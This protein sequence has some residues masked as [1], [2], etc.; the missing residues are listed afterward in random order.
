MLCAGLRAANVAGYPEE[1]FWHGNHKALAAA[2]ELDPGDQPSLVRAA[3][4]RGTSKNGVFGCK[5]MW[6]YLDDACA[7]LA[8]AFEVDPR[9][10]NA[11]I[12]QASFPDLRLV[13]LERADSVAQAISYARA[14]QSDVWAIVAGA[15]VRGSQPALEL[16]HV[17][18]G[19]SSSSPHRFDFHAVE[20]FRREVE[21]HNRAWRA[22][23][24][25]SGFE[26]VR[27]EFEDVVDDYEAT[28]TRVVRQL[29]L[30]APHED[31]NIPPPATERQSGAQ[32]A[33]WRL[34]YEE[35]ALAPHMR[36]I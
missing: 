30:V 21:R 35:R 17:G 33:R 11:E 29:G 3:I 27:V 34:R 5:V 7:M 1:Y 36:P 26:P 12:L 18:G 19:A 6:G 28:I 4:E 25:L 23:F 10:S 2:W 9:Q 14:V 15:E 32:S 24:E 16:P 20:Y 31:V 13:F 22:W 8:A